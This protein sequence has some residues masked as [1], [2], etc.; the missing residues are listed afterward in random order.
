M[1]LSGYISYLIKTLL[2][3][4][5]SFWPLCGVHDNSWEFV[6]GFRNDLWKMAFW[7]IRTSLFSF[8]LSLP[9]EMGKSFFEMWAPS[10]ATAD[11][12]SAILFWWCDITHDVLSLFIKYWV[13]GCV[14]EPTLI[15]ISLLY[16]PTIFS[17]KPLIGKKS[18][19]QSRDHSIFRVN[20]FRGYGSVRFRSYFFQTPLNHSLTSH[21]GQQGEYE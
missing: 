1:W 11:I 2:C 8:C 21:R 13:C 4:H 5:F 19:L 16:S 20:S 12:Q 15:T 14:T 9:Q 6:D 18:T 3:Y 7:T 10:M 17:Q